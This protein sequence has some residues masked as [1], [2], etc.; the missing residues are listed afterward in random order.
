[1]IDKICEIL[2]NKIRSE[3]K[4]IDDERA[5]AINY[6][7][8]IIIGELPKILALFIVA[9]ILKIG[10]YVLFAYVAILPYKVV[11]GGFH[12]K[13]N[14]GCTLGTFTYYFGT[15]YASKFLTIEPF[16]LKVIVASLIFIFSIIM[17][18]IYAPADTVNM[19][20][21]RKKER[22]IKKILSYVF[23]TLTLI[24]SLTVKDNT[25]SNILMINTLFVSISISRLAFKLTKNEYGYETYLRQGLI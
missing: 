11:A 18:S 5:E 13:T 23:M 4:D 7:L 6:G 10:W 21:L 15:V 2:T 25:I 3:S 9:F 24:A 20:I 8:H 16:A 17:I 22:K 12:L 14:I 1:M 19:P